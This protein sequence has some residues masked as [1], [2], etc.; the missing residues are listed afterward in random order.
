MFKRVLKG[1][2]ALGLAVVLS[3]GMWPA[4]AHAAGSDYHLWEYDLNPADVTWT[5][6]N[7]SDPTSKN[8]VASDDAGDVIN[9]HCLFY[10][11]GAFQGELW[12]KSN[13]A[14]PVMSFSGPILLT[15]G[16]SAE[17]FPC[18]VSITTRNISI[19][20]MDDDGIAMHTYNREVTVSVTCSS[21]ANNSTDYIE[22]KSVDTLV[23]NLG[24]S[25]PFEV[26]KLLRDNPKQSLDFTFEYKGEKHRVII[27]AGKAPTEDLEWYGPL[28]LLQEYGDSINGIEKEYIVVKDDNL[29]KLAK[30]FGVT[31]EYLIAKNPDIKNPD[32][33]YPGDII[34]Y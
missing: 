6:T 26:I 31:L 3:I 14:T 13:D 17:S 23:W 32:L 11:D 24:D 33:I 22:T 15:E 18:F 7:P 12:L 2:L 5:F 25:L 20:H 34:K 27:P 29:G 21:T 16:Y 19:S 30:K 4:S 28:W 8:F 1:M 10:K 9:I